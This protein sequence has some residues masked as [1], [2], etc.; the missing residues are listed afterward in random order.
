MRPTYG[1]S[2]LPS[3]PTPALFDNPSS[4]STSKIPLIITTVRNEGGQAVQQLFSCP[5]ESNN[6]TYLYTLAALIGTTRAGQIVNSP[7]YALPAS[8][9]SGSDIFREKFE[10]ATTDGTWRCP[11]RAVA[12]QW[13]GAGANVWVGE[14]EEG[15]TYPSNSAAGYCTVAGRVCHEVS[16]TEHS[17]VLY[18]SD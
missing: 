15:E 14:W 17:H 5:L 13:A 12:A 2:T 7:Q 18:W 11:S 8:T 16:R 3:D 1:T 9:E 10:L 4:L 6:N